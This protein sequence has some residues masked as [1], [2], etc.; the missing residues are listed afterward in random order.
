MLEIWE[1]VPEGSL[2]VDF[3]SEHPF[4]TE[5]NRNAM[6]EAVFA[7]LE[8]LYNEYP[9]LVVLK[10]IIIAS[11]VVQCYNVIAQ[12]STNI[13]PA[14][15]M[16]TGIV[17]GKVMHWTKDDKKNVVVFIFER[18][19]GG[20]LDIDNPDAVQ[21]TQGILRHECMHVVQDE[22]FGRTLGLLPLP[23]N[24]T[25][26]QL[27]LTNMSIAETAYSEYFANQKSIR[28]FKQAS[29][30][31]EEIRLLVDTIVECTEKVAEIREQISSSTDEEFIYQKW[32]F[33]IS[34]VCKL[35]NAMGRGLSLC[36]DEMTYKKLNEMIEQEAPSWVGIVRSFYDALADIQ[37][38]V[39]SALNDELRLN[40]EELFTNLYL[41]VNSCFHHLSVRGE[42]NHNGRLIIL[43]E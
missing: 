34:Y 30:E 15:N 20:L 13:V 24:I 18:I 38:R 29:Y 1:E 9:S 2:R 31:T 35:A 43:T 22:V 36:D 3:A 6:R 11:D 10:G 21:A 7:E 33:V 17:G 27:E 32:N 26:R 25:L 14:V 23:Q 8:E 4:W 40:R 42:L 12:E 28:L 5:E 37:R 19:I 41:V 39:E 16:E